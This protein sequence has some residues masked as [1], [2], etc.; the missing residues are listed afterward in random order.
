[1]DN[2]KDL[3]IL[4]ILT[5]K[6]QSLLP[7]GEVAMTPYYTSDGNYI[8]YA[9]SQKQKEGIGALNQWFLS[10]KHHIFKINTITKQIKQL[11]IQKLY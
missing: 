9:S 1:M 7:E 3:V 5:G 10:G 2:N 11:I 8:L 6:F 4:D